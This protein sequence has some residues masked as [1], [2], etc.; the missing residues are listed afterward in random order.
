MILFITNSR[1]FS[2][3]MK[4]GFIKMSQPD[5]CLDD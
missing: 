1:I 4:N 5:G 3:K 2:K